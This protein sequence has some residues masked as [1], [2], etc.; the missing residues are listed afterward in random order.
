M[1][2]ILDRWGARCA[3]LMLSP[4]PA[5]RAASS[6][7]WVPPLVPERN[8]QAACQFDALTRQRGA[9]GDVSGVKL[10][11]CAA[12]C[13]ITC[14]RRRRRCLAPTQYTHSA[15]AQTCGLDAGLNENRPAGRRSCAPLAR[16]SLFRAYRQLGSL[17]A[18]SGAWFT[19]RISPQE[20]KHETK[21]PITREASGMKVERRSGPPLCLAGHRRRL[22]ENALYVQMLQQHVFQ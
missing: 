22:W 2:S 15:I 11:S 9:G 10:R 7:A 1:D 20:T 21:Q 16:L 19:G 17:G 5:A 3:V 4:L 13:G 14:T 12:A 18:G 8:N 6:G